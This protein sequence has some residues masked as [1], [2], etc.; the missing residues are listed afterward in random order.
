MNRKIKALI[1][2]NVAITFLTMREDSYTDEALQIMSLCSDRKIE[3]YLAF[4]SLSIIWY[5]GR[6]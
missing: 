1:D 2:A 4:H 5:L 6:K 3:G